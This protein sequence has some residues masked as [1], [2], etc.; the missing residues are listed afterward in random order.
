MP[1]AA[2]HHAI[3]HELLRGL[4]VERFGVEPSPRRRATVAAKLR[5][6]LRACELRTLGEY[7][8]LLRRA[9]DGLDEWGLFADAITN[10]ETFLFRSAGQLETLAQLLPSLAPPLRPLRVLSA[11]CAS[12]EEAYSLAAVLAANARHLPAGFE[13]VGVD[14][15]SPRLAE[16]GAGRYAVD[17]L[18][19]SSLVPGVSV[20][21]AFEREGAWW[22]VRPQLRRAV[23][24]RL[25]NL[26]APRGLELGRFDVVF[27][28]NVLI[29]AHD[30]GWPRFVQT[31]ERALVPG[32][33]LFLGESETLLGRS[34]RLVLR[35]IGAHFAYVLPPWPSAS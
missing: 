2:V 30:E 1:E 8:Q 20:D 28:R 7:Y 34:E 6:R 13:V 24:F 11:G 4:A 12:G 5:Q 26:A 35:R 16:A 10:P 21:A 3:E 14:I 27:C 19:P 22:R 33:H 31:L 18:R 17:Q 23:T 29:Y 9:P 32:G 15:S 25:G